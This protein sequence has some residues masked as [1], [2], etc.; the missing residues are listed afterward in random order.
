MSDLRDWFGLHDRVAVVTG[1]SGALGSAIS[2]G[3]ATAGARV[4]MIGRNSDT[5]HAAADRLG[6]DGGEALAVP[7]DVLDAERLRAA[8]EQ[9][10]SRWG[11]VDILVN[12]A[13]GN[14]PAATL[15]PE[16]SVLDLDAD[17][18][19][20]VVE[21]NLLGTLLPTQVLGAAIVSS[22]RARAEPPRGS[23]VNVSSM[24]AARAIT[25]VAGYGAAKSAIESLTRSLAVELAR[26]CG[27]GVRVNAIAPGFF[28]GE[29]NRRL[30]LD[31]EGKLTPRGESII[32][33]TPAQR[34]GEA[35]ELI[36]T[37]LWLCGDGA[38]FVTGTVVP[39]DG[40]FSA[41]AGV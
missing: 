9:I 16:Q 38:S 29:Q 27:P 10:V 25:R 36:A 3:L 4:A 20:Q 22:A 19:R 12:A 13:G 41:F 40:G 37:V 17:A 34:F 2:R 33:R 39:V 7:A 18:F 30:L 5:L 21:L 1:G 11:R 24:A 23:I 31:S 32:A 15:A 6:A 14:V 35:A 8:A 26:S 28:I